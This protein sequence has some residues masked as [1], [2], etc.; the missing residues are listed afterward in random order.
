MFVKISP[1]KARKGQSRK[2]TLTL[3][4][5]LTPTWS[6]YW[7]WNQPNIMDTEELEQMT[8]AASCS[9]QSDLVLCG[10][11]LW[12]VYIVY[13]YSLYRGQSLAGSMTYCS[14]DGSLGTLYKGLWKLMF[15]KDF[16]H[17]ISFSDP[18][19]R[20]LSI[21][22]SCETFPK[23]DSLVKVPFGKPSILRRIG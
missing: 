6:Y 18:L 5:G 9:P 20:T 7:V 16:G 21:T 23:K 2:D 15:L 3:S 10:Q 1:N 8:P 17:L 14:S 12:W 22:K 13:L 4:V 19:Q 11:S